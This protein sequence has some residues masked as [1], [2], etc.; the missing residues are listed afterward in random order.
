MSIKTECPICKK[1]ML[2][3]SLNKHLRNIHLFEPDKKCECGREFEN[4]QS[5]NAHY[6]WCIVHRNGKLPKISNLGITLSTK[7]KT[8]E[9][10]YGKERADEMKKRLSVSCTGRKCSDETRK[11]LSEAAY[12]TIDTGKLYSAGLKGYYD[13]IWFDSSW[14]LAYYIFLKETG[15]GKLKRNTKIYFNYIDDFGQL[16]KTRPDFIDSFGNFIEIKGFP[17]IHTPAKIRSLQ[18]KVK[19]LF[20]KDIN[21]ALKYCRKKYGNN[22]TKKFYINTWVS[23]MAED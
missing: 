1:S 4:S 13:D 12:R 5:L 15:L 2:Q 7:G 10:L 8:W 11:K 18:N 3:T 21:H 20:K 9:E 17:N 23:Q 6:R 16:R 14:E 19:F 22:F